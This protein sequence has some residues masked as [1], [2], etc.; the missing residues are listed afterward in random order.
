MRQ[1][2]DCINKEFWLYLHFLD[3]YQ[4]NSQTYREHQ[5]ASEFHRVNMIIVIR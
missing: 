2:G 1:C 5:R 4:M 3:W